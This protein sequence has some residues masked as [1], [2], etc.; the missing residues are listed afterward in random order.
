MSKKVF[1]VNFELLTKKAQ[2]V[3]FVRF[4]CYSSFASKSFFGAKTFD[5]RT[6]VLIAPIV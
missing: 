4:S 1:V 5:Q 2:T 3:D 6:K